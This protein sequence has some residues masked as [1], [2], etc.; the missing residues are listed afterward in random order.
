MHISTKPPL[1]NSCSAQKGFHHLFRC[2]L[3]EVSVLLAGAH[4]DDWL[5][6][7]VHHRKCSTDLIVHCIVLRQNIPSMPR[8]F[9]G[10]CDMSNNDL[11]NFVT[12]SIAS[13]PTRAS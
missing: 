12:W 3:P 7:D 8:G 4:K 1:R 13:L 11:L 6:C 9:L 5:P 2:E 10:S